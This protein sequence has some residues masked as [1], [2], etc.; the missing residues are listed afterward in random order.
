MC[1]SVIV[2]WMCV[3]FFFLFFYFFFFI[4]LFLFQLNLSLCGSWLIIVWYFF[5][6]VSIALFVNVCVEWMFGFESFSFF[7]VLSKNR[8]LNLYTK[9]HKM[10]FIMLFNFYRI[11][12]T[13]CFIICI[14]WMVRLKCFFFSFWI[15][16]TE[17]RQLFCLIS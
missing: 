7:F 1:V 10:L 8:Q 2:G 5:F 15:I 9:K 14:T 11:Y 16:A 3:D 13:R 12:C 6:A 17:N 4:Y